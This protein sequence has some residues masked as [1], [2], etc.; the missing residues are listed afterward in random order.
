MKKINNVESKIN[1]NPSEHKDIIKKFTDFDN[2]LNNIDKDNKKKI[3]DIE[4]KLNNIDKDKNKPSDMKETNIVPN[5]EL[6]KKF[7][8]IDIKINSCGKILFD[9]LTDPFY[10]FQVYSVILWYCTE[11]YYYATVIVVLSVFSLIFFP[12]KIPNTIPIIINIYHLILLRKL[13][14]GLFPSSSF[15]CLFSSVL[16][17]PRDLGS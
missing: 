4:N 16:G 11:Y 15:I 8:D 13:I 12:I 2:K 10:L 14:K 1:I 3:G 9:E 6:E 5:K 17:V 7:T